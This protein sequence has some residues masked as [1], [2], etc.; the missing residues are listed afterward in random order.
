MDRKLKK[1]KIA[2]AEVKDEI[3][4]T[5]SKFEERLKKLEEKA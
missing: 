2:I 1:R 3:K 5:Y 4:N